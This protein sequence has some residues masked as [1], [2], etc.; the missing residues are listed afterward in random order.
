MEFKIFVL[1]KSLISVKSVT[2]IIIVKIM[3]MII[4]IQFY[5]RMPLFLRKY[6]E[7]NS[8]VKLH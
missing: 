2:A 4:I 7:K 1:Y 6:V 5:K 3:M 8:T